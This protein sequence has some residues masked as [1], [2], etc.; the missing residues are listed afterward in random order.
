MNDELKRFFDSIKFTSDKFND[1]EVK[2]VIYYSSL[3]QYEVIIISKSI[4]PKEEVDKLIIASKNKIKGEKTCSIK[5]EYESFSMEEKRAYA[6]IILN[7]FYQDKPSLGKLSLDI[8]GDT[9]I[10]KVNSKM[11]EDLVVRDFDILNKTLIT[12][13]IGEVHLK[14]S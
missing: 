7:D 6:E 13:G 14:Q 5:M 4:V 10:I 2:K 9:I 3:D 1:A 12:Y 8:N 11:A